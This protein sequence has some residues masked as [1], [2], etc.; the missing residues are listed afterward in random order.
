MPQSILIN[1]ARLR[2]LHAE[3]HRSA[4][5]R[6]DSAEAQSRW[7]QA[8]ARFH[9]EYDSL[10]YPGGLDAGLARLRLLDAAAIASAIQFLEAD[11]YFFRSGYVKAEILRRLKKA[12]LTKS[13]EQRLRNVVL[14]RI[15]GQDRRELRAYCRLAATLATPSFEADLAALAASADDRTARHAKWALAAL[16]SRVTGAT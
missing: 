3:I 8:S 2:E 13:Q 12:P 1:A 15:S 9:N 11:P 14:A 7:Q 10:A 4:R 5:T 16:S 6:N